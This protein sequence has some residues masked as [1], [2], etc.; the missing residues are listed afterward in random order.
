MINNNTAEFIKNIHYY[1]NLTT[2]ITMSVIGLVGNTLVFYILTRPKFLKQSI[3][4]Y[5]LVSTGNNSFVLLTMWLYCMPDLFLMNSNSLSCKLTQY[6]GYLFYQFCPWIIVLNSFDRYLSVHFPTKFEFRTKL[7]Y[8]VLALS[9]IFSLLSLIDLVFFFYYDLQISS[10]DITLRTCSTSG[11]FIAFCIDLA[12][13]LISTIIPFILMLFFSISTGFYLMDR[14]SRLHQNKTLKKEKQFLKIMCAMDVFFLL[15]NLPF[16]IQM[17]VF[18]SLAI[19]DIKY[20][21]STFIFD[22]TNLLIYIQCSCTFFIYLTCNVVFREYF[23]S[24][25]S[26]HSTIRPSIV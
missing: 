18:D 13:L 2:A 26:F 3:F 5:F 9:I 19:N 1:F 6:F 17:L 21:Y 23:I 4:R 14:K 11:V 15:C 20:S 22:V 10:N 16:C 25:F 7:K 24:M 12:N 8:Q